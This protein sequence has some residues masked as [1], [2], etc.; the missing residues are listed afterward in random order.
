MTITGNHALGIREMATDAVTSRRPSLTNEQSRLLA[1]LPW[2]RIHWLAFWKRRVE[3]W[4][5]IA[6]AVYVAV[7]AL[8]ILWSWWGTLQLPNPVAQLAQWTRWSP[9]SVVYLLDGRDRQGRRATF[10]MLVLKKGFDWARGSSDEL[11]LDGEQLDGAKAMAAA[12]DPKVRD[13][14]GNARELIA[15]G[16]ASQEGDPQREFARAGRRASKIAGWLAALAAPEVPIWT[17]NLGQYTEPCEACET[18]DTSW[19]RPFIVIG[20]READPLV[21]I[22]EALTTALSGKANVPSLARYSAF[23]MRKYR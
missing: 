16:A 8:V 7:I 10:E 15:V 1:G 21:D 4:M 23:E 11:M 22:G 5:E 6:A 2:W 12:F 17:L 20:V 18:G 9:N 3:S 14:L 13:N 19:Q